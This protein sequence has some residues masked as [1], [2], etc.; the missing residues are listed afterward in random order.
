MRFFG[1]GKVSS[2]PFFCARSCARIRKN[3]RSALSRRAL[4][5][6][7]ACLLYLFS[8]VFHAGRVLPRDNKSSGTGGGFK[9]PGLHEDPRHGPPAAHIG[10]DS[11]QRGSLRAS[12]KYNVVYITLRSKRQKPAIMRGTVRPK[13]RK[14]PV[15]RKNARIGGNATHGIEQMETEEWRQITAFY[16][17]TGRIWGRD[18]EQSWT[19]S[20]KGRGGAAGSYSAIRIYSPEAPPWLSAA[21]VEAL[22][23]LADCSIAAV[24]HV[25]AS[26]NRR[27]LL[28]ESVTAEAR[29]ARGE[30]GPIAG[31]RTCPGRCGIIK[32]HVDTSEVFAFH[33]DRI[34][35]LNR[36]LP[37]VCR[38][39]TFLRDSQPNPAVLW[40][41][42]L[43]SADSNL[44][45]SIQLT[46]GSYQRSLKHKC[47]HKGVAPRP[48]WGCSSIHHYEWSKLALF[49]FLLQVYNRLDRNCCGFKPRKE[50]ICVKLG[51]HL[52][53][54]D[55]D[56]VGL[57]HIV[58]RKHDP[59][60]LV[61][62]D[63]KGY[64]D[65]DEDN[66]DFKLL[67][68]IKELPEQAMSI[69]RSHH[70][71]ERLLQSLF[72]DRVYW[73]SQGGRQGIE[74]LI[75]VIERRAKVL[76]TYTNAHGIKIVPMNS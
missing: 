47:W 26:P 6:A 19:V 21:D 49:D 32:R 56:S 16:K 58:H 54:E 52:E 10:H 61:F 22:R 1:A 60:R 66:L 35:G 70:L 5:V 48:E 59:R 46:W 75:D 28:F 63:N 51:Q 2:A 36:S 20:P 18:T 38:K 27:L 68:G 33:L 55:Q 71:R 8:V 65:R 34:L 43:A 23:F 24:R 72:L 53:C 4:L 15:A 14:K 42:S 41:S 44:Q 69:L 40:D 11:A 9:S 50:D 73:E 45:S 76:L 67:Q 25:S 39:F 17:E 13:S 74:K 3:T 7:S 37:A 29:K 57:V 64:F 30:S 31:D 62:I 12:S